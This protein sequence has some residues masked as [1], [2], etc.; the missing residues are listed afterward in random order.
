MDDYLGRF[1]YSNTPL[2]VWG[3]LERNEG[4]FLETDYYFST[5]FHHY[6]HGYW[7]CY[8]GIPLE[9]RTIRRFYHILRGSEFRG[10]YPAFETKVCKSREE[11]SRE[12]RRISKEAREANFFVPTH[13]G[14]KWNCSYWCPLQSNLLNLSSHEKPKHILGMVSNDKIKLIEAYREMLSQ[15]NKKDQ[16]EKLMRM[17]KRASII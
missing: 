7:V 13:D 14:D 6:H 5:V 15:S 1:G 12:I 3:L 2:G 16:L 4:E 17:A 9:K 8:G 11:A 10:I